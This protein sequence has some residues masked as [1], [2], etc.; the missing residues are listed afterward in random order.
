[1]RHKKV[2]LEEHNLQ[3]TQVREA[4]HSLWLKRPSYNHLATVHLSVVTV[5]EYSAAKKKRCTLKSK[6]NLLL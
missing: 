4:Q 2:R 5:A 3:I 1:M 6:F